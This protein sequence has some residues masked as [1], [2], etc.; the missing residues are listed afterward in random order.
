MFA[1]VGRIVTRLPWLVITI[2]ILLAAA[3]ILTSPGLGGVTDAD[4]SAFLPADAESAR[5]ARLAERIFPDRAGATGVLVVTRRDGAEL[6]DSDVASLGQ[7]AQELNADRRPITEG[8]FFDPAQTVAPNHKV[9][10]LVAQFGGVAERADVQSAVKAIRMQA[11]RAL[12]GTS[13]TAAMTGQAAIVVDN[14]QAFLDAELIVTIATV[15][16]I[17]LLLL[18]IFRS[19]I[20]AFLPLL[21]VGLVFGVSLALVGTIAQALAV[22]VGQELPTMLTVVLFGIGTDYVLFLL[23]RYRERLRAGDGPRDA[24]VTAV[25][26]VGEAICS[27]AFAVIA[28]FGALVLAALGFFRTLGPALAIGVAVMLLAAL[29]LVPAIVALLGRYVFWPSRLTRAA[30]ARHLARGPRFVAIGRLVGRRPVAVLVAGVL[31][32]GGLA[33]AAVR[34]HPVYDP[35]AQLPPNTEATRAY[36]ELKLGFPAGSLNPTT[37]YLTADEPIETGAIH[38]FTSRCSFC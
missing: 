23:F 33:A 24:I 25:A 5:A 13:L 27:A 35:M 1:G 18:L 2:W 6:S 32:L 30:E 3:A 31:L 19:P 34:V 20:A 37:V 12:G 17:V 8:I 14:Q 22:R 28:A 36:Q 29:T 4:Q 10:M 21:A 26:R 7:L 38:D 15:G 9:A 16:L 11:A